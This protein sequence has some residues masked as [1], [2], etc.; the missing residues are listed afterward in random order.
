MFY[1]FIADDYD[2]DDDD[3]DD[4]DTNFNKYEDVVIAFTS[5]MATL[6][7][8]LR[9]SQ[10]EII[11]ARCIPVTHGK[12]RESIKSKADT[13]DNF[14][15]LLSDHTL[16]CNWM[17]I[18]LVEIIATAS[19]NRKLEDLV[20][21]YKRQIHSRNLRQIWQY[22]PQHEV[23]TE[24][25]KQVQMKI[26]KNP[27]DV[28]VEELLKC[29]RP[30]ANKIALDLMKVTENCITITWLVPTDKVYELFLFALTM[31][32]QSREDEFLQI[33]S[34]TI[35]HPKSILQKLKMEFG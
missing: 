32:Q 14:F 9:E 25:Y 3:G 20:N 5:L 22:I 34:W 6:Q 26:P 35:Y 4:V 28:T 27:D 33:G 31:P 10:L 12:F 13:V 21:K 29:D 15:K 19:R 23:M 1:L 30:L 16:Y 8:N 11:K 18:R 24:Y 17:N 2:N 7:K